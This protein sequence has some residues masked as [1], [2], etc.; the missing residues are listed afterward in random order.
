MMRSRLVKTLVPQ[1][2][3]E[4]PQ[5]IGLAQEKLAAGDRVGALEE[6]RRAVNRFPQTAVS[7]RALS[8]ILS[9]NDLYRYDVR[10]CRNLVAEGAIAEALDQ[11]LKATRLPDA[12]PADFL[13]AGYCLTGLGRFEEA[14]EQI[15]RSTDTWYAV[16]KPGLFATMDETWKPLVPRFLIVGV[17]K[18][19]T[20]SLHR[21]L[22]RHPR[23][24]AP[25]MKEIHFFGSPERGMDWYLAHFPRRPDWEER[26]VSGESRVDNFTEAN[27][28]ENVR[29]LLPA[30]RLVAVLRDPVE[31]AIS[32]YYHDRKIGAELRPLDVA[33]EEELECL[34]GSPEEMESKL[35]AYLH[36]QRRYLYYGLYE[37]HVAKWLSIFPPE[38]FLIVVS[39]ELNANPERELRR[40]FKH[41]GL[42][43]QPLGE[44]V[45][46]LPGTYDNQSKD[47]IRARLV[48]FYKRPNERLFELLGR[49]LNWQG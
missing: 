22:S 10:V 16:N 25:M 9:Q 32:H 11:S 24:L 44:Y 29:E 37:R 39:E 45:N 15:R 4:L 30:A 5:I 28:P 17:K 18:G 47:G 2:N 38:Q 1:S 13:Q 43:Y 6:A 20:T 34:S 19:G 49:R 42:K 31:R 23:V 3:G 27:V 8:N 41:I 40:V 21:F 36:T 46:K 35:A 7:H 33:F 26:F 14:A 48:E 12:V